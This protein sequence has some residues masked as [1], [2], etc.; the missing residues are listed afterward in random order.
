MGAAGA[1]YRGS[2]MWLGLFLSMLLLFGWSSR[3]CLCVW[4]CVYVW[5]GDAWK[6]LPRAPAFPYSL[7]HAVRTAAQALPPPGQRHKALWLPS[8]A[9]QR[10][11][12]AVAEF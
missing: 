4:V 1:L 3:E 8:P 10:S 11:E 2:S 6:G 5:G 9:N 12:L 7:V